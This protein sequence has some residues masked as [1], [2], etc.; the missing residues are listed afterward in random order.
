LVAFVRKVYSILFVQIVAT[1]IVGGVL[2]QSTSAITWI[3]QK[4]VDY[5]AFAAPN[6]SEH[7]TYIFLLV[8]G[9]STYLF[10]ALLSS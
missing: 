5:L 6:H 3:Q 4:Y 1:A 8:F 9:L 10:L 7:A 2:S